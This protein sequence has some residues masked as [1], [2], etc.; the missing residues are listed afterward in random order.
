M[1]CTAPADPLPGASLVAQA[2][3][4]C[5]FR[6]RQSQKKRTGKNVPVLLNRTRR[7][8]SNKEGS[9]RGAGSGRSGLGAIRGGCGAAGASETGQGNR[10]HTRKQPQYIPR[11]KLRSS[12]ESLVVLDCSNHGI[13]L[14]GGRAG[15]HETTDT[16]ASVLL[17]CCPSRYTPR[18]GIFSRASLK[19]FVKFAMQITSVSSTICP[20]S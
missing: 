11:R 10:P 12:P 4:P 1:R 15:V 18:S 8:C 9:G 16:F 2:L 6:N 17:Y 20:S 7:L 14:L 3:C 5:G 19:R 13:I